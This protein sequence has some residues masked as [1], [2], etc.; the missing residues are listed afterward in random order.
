MSKRNGA[1]KAIMKTLRVHSFLFAFTLI[2]VAVSA[3]ISVVPSLVLGNIIDS[4]SEGLFPAAELV[5]L[6]FILILVDALLSSGKESLLVILGEKMTHSL[7]NMMA[8]KLSRIEADTLLGSNPGETAALFSSDVDTLE[9]LFS[10]GVLSM[11]SDVCRIVSILYVIAVKNTGLFLILLVFLPIFAVFTRL[12]QKRRLSAE[13]DNRRAVA[14]VSGEVPETVH[15][16]RTIHNLSLED[17]MEKRYT[18]SVRRS[19]RAMER[20][21]F[22][23]AGYPVVVS[24]LQAVVVAAVM[25]LSSSGNTSILTF[26]GMSVG[27][28]VTVMS[29]ISNIFTPISSLG[30]EAEQIVSAFAGI[31]KIDAFLSLKERSIPQDD[32]TTP[33]G[34]ITL[35]SVTFGYKESP[36]LKNFSLEVKEGEQ[37]LVTGRTGAGKSTLFKLLLGLYKPLSGK[38]TVMGRDAY[39]IPDSERRRTIS[40]VEQKFRAIPGT[41]LDEITLHDPGITEKMVREALHITGLWE[42]VR[43]FQDGLYT[44]YRESLFSEGEREL[45]SISRAVVSNPK[46]LLLDEITA[47]LDSGT[48]EMVLEALA[49]ASEGRTVIS[50]SHRLYRSYGIRTVEIK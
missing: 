42:R 8:E 31:R 44:E 11:L 20:S 47:N 21:N 1:G 6:Y 36:V 28:S 30:M 2:S 17:Y 26:F 38:A 19:Y 37:V 40:C 23:D 43:S 29:C 4:L 35:D 10:S 50:I 14:K 16:I 12:T 41:V 39:M 24:L 5:I 9:K 13:L 25:L 27:T 32:G 46:I 34:G 3:G 45:L 48:E 33:S 18:E 49:K 15:N 7:R 22:Y